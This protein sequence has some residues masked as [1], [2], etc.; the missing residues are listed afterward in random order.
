[1]TPTARKENAAL[2]KKVTRRD[3]AASRMLKN[4]TTRSNMMFSAPVV[5]VKRDRSAR[6]RRTSG[7]CL[8]LVYKR[9]CMIFT[10]A[11]VVVRKDKSALG[12]APIIQ[13]LGVASEAAQKM[14]LCNSLIR[15][16][17]IMLSIL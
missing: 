13:C 7:E 8:G 12:Q 9:T 14:V 10:T 2:H 16:R 11:A 3:A 5:R 6:D 17:G 4:A 1:V 15:S